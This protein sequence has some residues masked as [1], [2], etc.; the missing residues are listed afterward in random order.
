MNQPPVF[1]PQLQEM[2]AL[3]T[4][5]ARAVETFERDGALH[6]VV[7]QLAEDIPGQAPSMTEGNSDTDTLV[8]RWGG[9]AFALHQRLPVPGGEDAES[10]EIGGELYLATASLRSGAGPYNMVTTSVIW[11]WRDGRFEPFQSVPSVA[12]KQWTHFSLQGRHFLLLAQGAHMP[13]HA[14]IAPQAASVIFQ[15]NGERF[16][17]FQEIESA[18]GY[19]ARYF[20]HAGQHFLAYADHVAPSR[21]LRWNGERFEDHQVFEGGSGRAFCFFRYGGQAW[22]VF[23]RLLGET[24]L[25]RWDGG[26]FEPFQ[27]LSGPGGRELLWLDTPDGGCLVKVNFIRGTR[28]APQTALLSQLMVWRDGRLQECATFDTRGGT[29]AAHFTWQGRRFLA[30]SN[31]LSAEVR[32]AEHTRIFAFQDRSPA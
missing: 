6:L 18:W 16:E 32:F 5:G 27:T 29:D 9:A 12:A 17:P 31:S 10:F 30:V 20:E 19:N 28:E 7:P 26:A 22:L 2:Q 13:G 15:W 1:S 23:A 3:A 14:A 25:Y 4:S 21:L 8:Y 11:R 24:T